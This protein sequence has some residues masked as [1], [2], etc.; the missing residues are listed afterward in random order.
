MQPHKQQGRHTQPTA[1]SHNLSHNLPG[2]CP[3]K[4]VQVEDNMAALAVLPKLTPEVLAR[5]DGIVGGQ[6][7]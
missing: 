1:L 2:A 3:P 6:H 5:I 7:E 4:Q